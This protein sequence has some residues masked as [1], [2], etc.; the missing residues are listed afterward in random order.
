MVLRK[1]YGVKICNFS[2]QN[3]ICLIETQGE[4]HV[5][6]FIYL[7]G[8]I[9]FSVRYLVA[10]TDTR[11]W[12]MTFNVFM[13]YSQ[14]LKWLILQLLMAPTILNPLPEKKKFLLDRL[15]N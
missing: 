9:F 2:V 5:D 10:I 13:G 12:E 3:G 7:F 15:I 6:L 14:T 11:K 4:N 1:V 8:C